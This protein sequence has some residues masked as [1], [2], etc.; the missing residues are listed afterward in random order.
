MTRRLRN[1]TGFMLVPVLF[2]L[3]MMLMMGFALAASV[4]T[5]SDVSRRERTRE[6][7]YNLAESALTAQA[8]QLGR[9]WPTSTTV[10]TPPTQC[11][12]TST[13][14]ACPQASAISGGYTATDYGA[15]CASS[16]TTPLW[17]TTVR[18]NGA[19]SEQYWTTAVN[20][21]SAYDANGDGIVWIRSTATVR[22]HDVGIVALVSRG[23]VPI[24]FSSNAVTANFITT[25]NQGKKV[26]IDTVGAYAQPPSAQINPS[27][28]PGA[29]VARCSG[30]SQ[31]QCLKYDSSKGQIQPPAAR[32]DSTASTSALSSSQL[33]SLE[34]QAQTAGKLYTTCP[35]F[36]A[37]QLTSTGGAP[38]VIKTSTPCAVSIGSNNVVNSSAS[39]GAL[40]IENGTLSMSGS[41]YFYGLLYMVNQQGSNGNVVTIQGNATIQGV[42]SIDGP[43][44][45]LAGSSKTNVIYDPRAST[46]LK[47]DV[48]AAIKKNTIRVLA[49]GTA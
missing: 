17:K 12:P 5:Q 11:D 15:A 8:G 16:P 41:A 33:A 6:S 25:S 9:S 14:T 43:G 22:C 42:I 39:P 48:G 49:K 44:G 47:G 27:A 28:Q 20:S 29:V 10:P 23:V 46:S 37:A 24:A 3:L 34:R 4:D 2:L 19:S 26:I 1:E 38:V 21:R 45:I 31:A 30:M 18:D 13:D 40:V 7:S 35:A 32:T 36:T